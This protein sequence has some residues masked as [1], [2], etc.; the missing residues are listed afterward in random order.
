MNT[1]NPQ[2]AAA[3]LAALSGGMPIISLHLKEGQSLEDA[4]REAEAEH[5]KTCP[6]CTA[7]YEAQQALEKANA[8]NADKPKSPDTDDDRKVASRP[9][10]GAG[11]GVGQTTA[12]D[13]QPVGYMVFVTRRN[14][15]GSRGE[16]QAIGTSF[17][18]DYKKCEASLTAF[19][20]SSLFTI[21]ATTGRAPFL[22]I[23]PV[24]AD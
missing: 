18:T 21:I 17:R 23:K 11:Y 5:R 12:R 15:D 2:F 13:R 16:T 4:I 20:N 14:E 6:N 8:A 22:E 1:N 7:E 9:E 24:F 19:Q 10:L 3:L